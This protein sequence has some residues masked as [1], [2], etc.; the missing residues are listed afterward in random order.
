M[1]N[2]SN[3]GF[4]LDWYNISNKELLNEL[5]RLP[6]VNLNRIYSILLSFEQDGIC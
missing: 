2:T 3:A 6:N 5:T 4:K 1:E